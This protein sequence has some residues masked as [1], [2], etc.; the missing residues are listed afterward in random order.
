MK[1]VAGLLIICILCIP[2]FSVMI[3]R[4]SAQAAS[5]EAGVYTNPVPPGCGFINFEEGV[6]GQV[7]RSTIPGLSFTTTLGYDWVYGDVRTGEYN[8]RSLTDPTVNHGS[9]VVNGYIFA[10]LG[11]NTGEGRI[12]FVNGARASYVSV[13]T[14]TNSGLEMD[15]Y[16][17]SGN[18]IATSGWANGNYGTYT[19]T[20]LT[21]Q[22]P[23]IAYVLIHDTGNYWLI[24]DIVANVG[25]Q[26]SQG[27]LQLGQGICACNGNVYH[28]DT[29]A[30]KV[31]IYS[32]STLNAVA[33]PIPVGKNPVS[34]ATFEQPPS[35]FGSY[36][37]LL[38]NIVLCANQG[39]GTVSIINSTTN[40]VITTKIVGTAPFG[41]ATNT[42]T[43]QAFLTD[44]E[45]NRIIVMTLRQFPQITTYSIPLSDS[46][47]GIAVDSYTNTVYV[48]LYNSHSIDV[49]YVNPNAQ[50]YSIQG[51]ILV[52]AYPMG[53]GLDQDGDLWVANSG[54]ATVSMV[55]PS[56]EQ[57][58]SLSV[59]KV[60]F[61]VDLDPVGIG[62]IDG[63][64]NE[65]YQISVLV[66]YQSS[67]KLT[68][69]S[70]SLWETQ[71][72]L[73]D[74]TYDQ[75]IPGVTSFNATAAVTIDTA[76][77]YL[78]Y[79][80]TVPV[81]LETNSPSSFIINKNLIAGPPAFYSG[82]VYMPTGTY[83]ISYSI[84]AGYTYESL[85][86]TG[87]VTLSADLSSI[88][89]MGAG[90]IKLSAQQIPNW[91]NSNYFSVSPFYISLGGIQSVLTSNNGLA[92]YPI[93][94]YL[95]SASQ[96]TSESQFVQQL[97]NYFDISV[98][99]GYNPVWVI[100]VHIPVVPIFGA[101][102]NQ[103]LPQQAQIYPLGGSVSDASFS[104]FFDGYPYLKT[105]NEGNLNIAITISASTNTA[106]TI[107]D[108]VKLLYDTLSSALKSSPDDLKNFILDALQT[109]LDSTDVT[110]NVI[111]SDI[112]QTGSLAS[113]QLMDLVTVDSVLSGA[114][115]IRGIIL[116]V[117]NMMDYWTKADENFAAAATT[118]PPFDA[119]NAGLGIIEGIQGG[120]AFFDASVQMLPFVFP[121]LNNN[122]TFLGFENAVSYATSMIDPSGSTIYPSFYDS[123]GS[124]VLGYNHFSG[125]FLFNSSEGI[126]F[127]IA[128]S[129]YAYLKENPTNTTSYV[130]QLS[131][132]G[133]NESV[134]YIVTVRSF[135]TTAPISSYA[136][137][138]TSRSTLSIHT[139]FSGEGIPVQTSYLSPHVIV[140]ETGTG[141]DLLVIP[142]K[143]DGVLTT[144]SSGFVIVNGTTIAMQELNS[145]TFECLIPYSQ[146]NS[147]LAM[148]YLFSPGMAGGYTPVRLRE[149]HVN[150]VFTFSPNPV[151][152]Y[153]EVTF[154]ATTSST[155]FGRI[156]QYSWSFGDGNTNSTS[157][158]TITHFYA[159]K[160]T[161]NVT[162]TVLNS[163]GLINST[164]HLVTVNY[165]NHDVTV[166]SVKVSIHDVYQGWTVPI[167]VTAANVGNAT[168]TFNVTLYY[169][170]S[171]I[172]IGTQT[173]IN[174]APNST[175]VLK[176]LWNT[177]NVPVCNTN[178][179][180]TAEASVVTGE[181]NTLNN[182]LSEGTVRIRIVG[183]VNG[184]G[185]VDLRDLISVA[186]CLGS[187]NG[188]AGGIPVHY[189]G[190]PTYNL[191]ADFNQDGKINIL[192]MILLA[193]H[194][195]QHW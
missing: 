52:G 111:T 136:G 192:D 28:V 97:K 141:F 120:F 46:P 49:I 77:N 167:N 55:L 157:S 21:V 125:A 143:N 96:S 186:E 126:L 133:G 161:Y 80:N 119:I 162:L 138:L 169:N 144:A 165:L 54:S 121:D 188:Q 129:Y 22:A 153:Q 150:T 91:Q 78:V 3:P 107:S 98:P 2:M 74:L 63:G 152:T 51:A 132:V 103:N 113:Y 177:A 130:L 8:A 139:L 58:S 183:D 70:H 30:N 84:P 57:S 100:L 127:R 175:I 95:I 14:S 36:Y 180:I 66:S 135:N 185:K 29:S 178:Y 187:V 112:T 23:N 4:M 18:L 41:I 179:T 131:Q 164:W 5:V 159:L 142:Y 158:P 47:T 45:S 128:D 190:K 171:L 94:I 117:F 81:E 174:L 37:S 172:L 75:V 82:G 85:T 193:T 11:P 124:L 108:L 35:Y 110:V 53:L 50:S 88:S 86:A 114:F 27:S 184:D 149:P 89:V 154:N 140:S 20:R 182:V 155:N 92:Q 176:Y 6:D 73:T 189:S 7:I 181:T 39:D 48:S 33:P 122:P 173:V 67:N 101:I 191:Y 163:A 32:Q 34:L 76:K 43:G 118:P 25:G 31:E 93:G 38:G 56:S 64:Y 102:L 71:Q 83:Q 40:S 61:P 10:W 60:D 15:A 166:A 59:D 168:E 105:D 1:R 68:F 62:I 134:P 106:Q 123:T 90:T 99:S 115:T 160:G 194:L 69:I 116:D 44:F 9:Y 42:I 26:S 72:P 17:S 146:I 87:D 148:V 156:I 137:I 12:D 104:A 13:L 19:F 147:N 151:G 195:G 24:D 170:S 65:G 16:D 109:I 79:I 145:S